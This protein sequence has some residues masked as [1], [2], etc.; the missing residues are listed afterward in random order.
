MRLSSDDV[1]EDQAFATIA[2]AAA[3][4]LTVFDTAHAYGGGGDPLGQNERLVA[5]AL[6]RCGGRERARIVTKGGMTRTGGG[7]IPDGR[8]RAIRTD[9]EA[10]IAALDGLPIDLY[11]LHAPDPRTSWRTSVRALARLVEDGL[12]S[13]IG[14]SNVS[15]RQLQ[16]ALDLAPVAAVE[17]A[18]SPFDDGAERGGLIE[19]CAKLGITVLAHTPLGGPRRAA[20]LA[21]KADLAA[22]ADAHRATP[23]ETALAWLLRISPAVVA[24]P[25]ARRPE[26]ARSAARA[27][28]L[29]LDDPGRDTLSRAF[30]RS[31]APLAARPRTHQDGDVVL[32]MGIP[33]AGKTHLAAEYVAR[34]Y[35]RLNRD[36]RGGSL[37][38]LGHEL[39]R[40]LASGARHVV[41]DNT[42]LTRASRSHVVEAAGR[43]G[44]ATRCVWL[45][46]PLAQAQVNVIGRMLDRLGS[47]PGPDDLRALSRGHLGVITPTSQM[48]AL[49]E[50]EPPSDDEGLGVVERVPFARVS[51]SSAAASAVLVAAAALDRPGW[52]AA[53]EGSLPGAPHLVF[54]WRPG[55]GADALDT[56]VARVAAEVSGPV[57]GAVCPHRAGPP[58][59]WCRPPL[60]G[61]ALVFAHSRHADLSR[62]VLIGASHAHRTMAAVLGAEFTGL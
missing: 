45:E 60:P 56:C 38:E 62:S 4:G 61:L 28:T 52:Q 10:S 6:I 22:V 29:V 57:D 20:A 11:L 15:H 12:V 48:R 13:H 39:D 58:E 50:L 53:L 26:T 1:G 2:A 9:C 23:A 55:A 27:A 30:G 37:R 24:L 5:R 16:E 44:V 8:A 33:G 32:V 54:D 49:R 3:A 14:L 42:W 47:L 35:V 17:V 19:A 21:R 41:L 25:G 31:R 34:G 40:T 51:A 46:T 43:H 18:L 36:E 7:W 59:C